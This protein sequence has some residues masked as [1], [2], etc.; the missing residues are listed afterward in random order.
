MG[1]TEGRANRLAFARNVCGAVFAVVAGLGGI[2][3][4]A[5]SP[6]WLRLVFGGLVVAGGVAVVAL[7]F[8]ERRAQDRERAAAGDRGSPRPIPRTIPNGPMKFV[9]RVDELRRL[10][11]LAERA[12]AASEPVTAVLSGLPGVGKTAVGKHWANGARSRFADGDLFADFSRRRR[13]VGIDVSGV[14]GDFIRKL[15]PPG[16]VVPPRLEDRVDLFQELAYGRRL[17]IVLDDVTEPAQVRQLVPRGGGSLVLATSYRQLEELHYEGAEFI[18]VNL[19]TEDRARRLLAE[20]AGDQGWR[21]EQEPE[22]TSE[23]LGFCG[24]LALPL[25]VCAARLLI[26]Q[27]SVGVASLVADIA[28]ERRRLGKLS[29]KG[30]YAAAAVFGFAYGDLAPGDRLVY[31]RLG[32]HPGVDLNATHAALLAG[33]SITDAER[34]LAALADT[35]LLEPLIDGRYRF[36]GLIRLHAAESAEREEG[37]GVEELER[38]LVDWY[39]AGVRAAD[40]TIIVDR[41]RLAEDEVPDVG[42]V[43]SFA[44]RQDAFA[45]LE[46]ERANLRAV[47]EMA[48]RREWDTRVWQIVEALWPF[49]HNRRHYADWIDETLLGI[50]SARRADHQE[51]EARLHTQ[52]SVAFVDL[53][54]YDRAHDHLAR[55]EQAARGSTNLRLRGSVR[56]FTGVCYMNEERYD[57]ALAA[58]R[59]ARAMMAAIGGERGV[60]IQNYFIGRTLMY[61][62]RYAGALEA[63]EASLETMRRIDDRLFLGRLALRRGEVLRRDGRLEEAQTTLRDG[64]EILASLGM[65]LEEAESHEEL[66]AIAAERHDAAAAD[67]HRE[68]AQDIYRSIGHPRARSSVPPGTDRLRSAGAAL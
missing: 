63:L 8:L 6:V 7:W 40:R 13:G 17:L 29:G 45:W 41:L 4:T 61:M 65:R 66:A 14:L 53:L 51:A 46:A 68:R 22:A 67:E 48:A 25:C 2:A 47:L 56:E 62:G 11:A 10:D 12:D 9:N 27:G 35:H 37:A 50:A 26:N 1:Q 21:F 30:E 42:H 60:G 43:P 39:Y 38:R 31:R 64:I 24:G 34:Q 54:E 23:L 59:E 52:V 18:P 33:I 15:G 16:Q 28:D 44:T 5:G 32:V 19:L 20:M 57:E 3:T 36:H 49:H 58:F 55:A